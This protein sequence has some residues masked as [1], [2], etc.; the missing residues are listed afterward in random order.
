MPDYRDSRGNRIRL[1]DEVGSGGEGAVYRVQGNRGQVAKIWHNPTPQTAEKITVMVRRRPATGSGGGGLFGAAR[2]SRAHAP[3]AWPD[4]VLY[5]DSNQVVGFLMPYV[6]LS[7]F[8]ESQ[9][10]FNP[11]A[12]RRTE[13]ELN[14]SFGDADLLQHSP[15]PGRGGSPDSRGRPRHRGCQ[16]EKRAGQCPVRHHDR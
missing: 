1:G 15:Q 11:T 4:D 7:Q 13:R 14:A 6:D 16:R 8:R 12:R 5:D 9:A 10:F 3:F 2:R